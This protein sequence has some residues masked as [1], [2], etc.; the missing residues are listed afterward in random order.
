[1]NRVVLITLFVSTCYLAESAS[2]AAPTSRPAGASVEQKSRELL[3]AWKDRLAEEHFT[4]VIA[5]PFV[6]AGDGGPARRA[7]SRDGTTLAAA[8]ALHAHFF[9]AEP[10]A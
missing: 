1:M 3:A 10:A 5:G 2:A 7:R 9:R 8:R 6:I 4:A